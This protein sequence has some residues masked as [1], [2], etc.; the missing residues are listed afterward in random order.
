M[1]EQ[2]VQSTSF[3]PLALII[4]LMIAVA[5]LLIVQG[6]KRRGNTAGSAA[7]PSTEAQKTEAPVSALDLYMKKCT[8]EQQMDSMVSSRTGLILLLQ[9]IQTRENSDPND[10]NRVTFRMKQSNLQ[11]LMEEYDAL[12]AQAKALPAEEQARFTRTPAY[13]T[14]RALLNEKV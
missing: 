14:Y 2:A 7:A 4:M 1:Q 8:L 5:A 10:I 9:F 12:L 6:M 13:E 11:A 3:W